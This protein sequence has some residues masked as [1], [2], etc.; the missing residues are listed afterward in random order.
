M[1]LMILWNDVLM[2]EQTSPKKRGAPL[3]SGYK[4]EREPITARVP[5]GTKKRLA[6]V[7]AAAEGK[8][9]VSDLV[10]AMVMNALPAYEADLAMRQRSSAD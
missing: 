2:T 6:V 4:G 3:G 8:M 7:A 5:L 1:L 10:C 9:N